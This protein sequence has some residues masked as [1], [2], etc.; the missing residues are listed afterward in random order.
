MQ[1]KTL[2]IF[3]IIG[4]GILLSAC[5]PAYV[6]TKVAKTTVKAGVGLTKATVNTAF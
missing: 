6:A 1:K 5:A 3:M 2:N 4:C